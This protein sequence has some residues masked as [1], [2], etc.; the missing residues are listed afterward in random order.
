MI[1]LT[2]LKKAQT[3]FQNH[4]IALTYVLAGFLGLFTFVFHGYQ[5]PDMPELLWL[6]VL[7]AVA[8]TL[9]GLPF[10]EATDAVFSNDPRAGIRNPYFWLYAYNMGYF[11]AVLMVIFYLSGPESLTHLFIQ[12]GLTGI[13]FGIAMAYLHRDT[14]LFKS[15]NWNF[16]RFDRQK[17]W[18][19]AFPF[20]SPLLII[21]LIVGNLAD[22][23]TGRTSMTYI[24][25]I[26]VFMGTLVHPIAHKTSHPW[27]GHALITESPRITGILILVVLSY[28]Q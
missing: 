10:V 23:K 19:R 4:P 27:S 6:K 15:D 9:L 25:V 5:Y 20:L 7:F 12:W 11:W 21:A 28:W 17:P 14:P 16:E 8:A 13:L 3:H 24:L 18:A 22:L 2:A 1:S 26:A